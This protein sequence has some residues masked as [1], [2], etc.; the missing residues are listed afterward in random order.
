MPTRDRKLRPRRRA[1]EP[2]TEA[3]AFEDVL[4]ELRS[5]DVDA[6]RWREL[7]PRA[8]RALLREKP[9]MGTEMAG[10]LCDVFFRRRELIPMRPPVGARDDD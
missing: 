5:G 6:D 4:E 7:R 3:I 8:I 2:A 9:A 1:S 10:E